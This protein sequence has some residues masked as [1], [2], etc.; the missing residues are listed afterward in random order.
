MESLKHWKQ[1]MAEEANAGSKIISTP[2]GDVQY[3]EVGAGLPVLHSHGSPAGCDA[4]PRAFYKLA[5]RGGLHWITPSRPGFLKTSLSVGKSSEQ[6]ADMF[7]AVMDALGIEKAVVHGWSG[8]GPPAIEAAKKYPDRFVGLILY[9]CVA[10][11]WGHRVTWF[12]KMILSDPGEW[13]F[14]L[15]QKM[16]PETFRK[17]TCEEMGLDYDYLKNI[18]E[19]VA[20][21]DQL[22]SF[23]SP[24]SLR[25]PGSFNDIDNYRRIVDLQLEKISI[26]TLITFSHSDNQLPF[27]NAQEAADK[28]P[29]ARLI[30]F[31]YG[32]HFPMADPRSDYL[33]EEIIKFVTTC[34]NNPKK[35]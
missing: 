25:N 17:K 22:F 7:V 16:S 19:S 30:D 33:N 28:I 21:I 10:D 8:G 4:G 26:P 14:S 34:H 13:I 20:F 3:T 1:R 5:T 32:G 23:M 2:M 12:E 29:N 31:E 27:S 15:M 9:S 6:Q 24:A 35:P 11:H 18:P